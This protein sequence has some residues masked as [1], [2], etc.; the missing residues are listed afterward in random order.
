MSEAATAAGSNRLGTGW[1]RGVSV[2]HGVYARTG[3]GAGPE[4]R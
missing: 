3:S 1:V 2:H 4:T